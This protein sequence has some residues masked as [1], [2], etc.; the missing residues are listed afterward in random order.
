VFLDVDVQGFEQV[1]KLGL[2]HL[3]VFVTLSRFELFRERLLKR[4]TETEESI[5][6]RLKTAEAELAWAPKY[7]A[8]V[9]NDDLATATVQFV[10]LIR[11]RFPG[12]LPN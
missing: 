5:A 3:S 8:I 2:E 10:G 7:D 12:W 11:G 1:K 9:E 4:G 6:R